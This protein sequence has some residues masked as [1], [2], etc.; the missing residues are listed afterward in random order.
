MSLST[1]LR[2]HL[3]AGTILG[4]AVSARDVGAQETTL[5]GFV[6]FTAARP[7]QAGA[8]PSFGL[9]QYDLFIT[10]QLSKRV[11]FLGESVFEYDE[12][13]IVDVERVLISFRANEQLRVTVGKHHT[14]IGYWNN[15]Y[16]HGA[17]LQPTINRPQMFRFED[18]GGVLPIHATGVLVSGREVSPLHLGYELLVGNGIGSAP[19]GDNDNAKSYAAALHSQVTSALKV[20]VS[21]YTD[22]IAASALAQSGDPLA[23]DVSARLVGA[24]VSYFGSS[25]EVLTE[26]QRADNHGR[27]SDLRGRTDAYYAYAGFRVRSVVP[28]VRYDA[29]RFPARDP[30]FVTDDFTMAM[31]GVRVDVAATVAVKGEFARQR[32]AKAGRTAILSAQVAIGF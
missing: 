10:S 22:Q 15:A 24:F 27:T 2:R 9:G 11:S 17:L 19:T 14:P 16:H 30:Y 5:R 29:L 13:F 7:S 8:T 21:A 31:A 25:L 1:V 12:G 26:Y 20:G 32:T 28:Y 23:E 4:A 3:C 18:E 6:D